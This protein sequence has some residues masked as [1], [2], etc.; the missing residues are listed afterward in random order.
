MGKGHFP[1]F[2]IYQASAV[3]SKDTLYLTS[4][5][6]I[7]NSN[8]YVLLTCSISN[9]IQLLKPRTIGARIKKSSQKKL[10]Q[11]QSQLPVRQSYLVSA[12]EELIAVG[13]MDS[14]EHSCK[15][16]YKYNSST[17]SWEVVME[18]SIGRSSSLVA[19]FK[20]NLLLVV[21][22]HKIPTKEVEALSLPV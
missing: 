9:L 19:V 6:G 13:G 3:V 12:N 10:W 2:P 16:V 22:G 18:M 15:N 5:E 4:G 17:N 21:G 20:G 8:A 1:P 7:K 14:S 11:V